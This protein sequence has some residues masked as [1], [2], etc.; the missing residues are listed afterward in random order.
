MSDEQPDPS[1]AS[2]PSHPSRARLIRLARGDRDELLVTPFDPSVPFVRFEFPR[3]PLSLHC[4]LTGLGSEFRR[5]RGRCLAALLV[6]D[7]RG[8]RWVQPVVPAQSCGADG[9]AW[10]LDCGDQELSPDDRI[11]GSFQM[12]V[13]RDLTEAMATVPP[14]DG[15]HIVQTLQGQRSFAYCF[16]HAEGEIAILPVEGAMEDDWA[17]ALDEAAAW[18]TFE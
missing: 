3:L 1:D 4:W 16:L 15:L 17:I 13:A 12:R 18:M 11:A 14:F 8:G 2:D 6:L 5:R 9:S 10:T 7:C